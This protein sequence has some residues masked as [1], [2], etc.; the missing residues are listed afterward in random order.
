MPRSLNL[1][2]LNNRII[3]C[4]RCPRLVEHCRRVAVEKTARY[5][6]LPYWGR[7]VPNFLPADA[8]RARL[9]IV[10]LAPGAH[11]ANRTGRMFTGDRSGDFLFAAMHRAG[12]CNQAASVGHG[13]GLALIDTVVTSAAHCAPPG[14]RPTAEELAACSG[15]LAQTFD[16]L[17]DLRAVVALGG[18]AH[19]AVLGLYRTRGHVDR[20]G[21]YPFGHGAWHAFA[22]APDLVGCYHPSQQN[23]FTGR[24]TPDMLV[25]VLTKVREHATRA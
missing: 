11:G 22:D 1:T 23:T 17:P 4:D 5:R 25:A 18:I 7:P 6:E 19:R 24:L 2:T 8:A 15:Y 13:D 10:G 3:R 20:V 16:A 21:R 9:L 12:L 14:N